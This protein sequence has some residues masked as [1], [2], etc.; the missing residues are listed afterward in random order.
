MYCTAIKADGTKC[1]A[2]ALAGEDQCLFHSRSD[3]AKKAR[4]ASRPKKAMSRRELLRELTADF[5]NVA[6]AEIDEN[7][8]LRIRGK[9]AAL[10]HDLI[11]EVENLREIEAMARE[12]KHESS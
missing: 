5:R 8:K 7:E 10:I 12:L 4:L 3:R 9:L 6:H 1:Q 11:N 2:L